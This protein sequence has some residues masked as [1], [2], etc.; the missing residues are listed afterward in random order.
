MGLLA[1][2]VPR[3]ST[4]R[5][6]ARAWLPAATHGRQRGSLRFFLRGQVPNV[7]RYG[8]PQ[9]RGKILS[10]T[11]L[12]GVNTMMG[13]PTV[14]GSSMFGKPV[15]RVEDQR[16]LRGQG[17]YVGDLQLPGTLEGLFVRSPHAHARIVAI[18]SSRARAMPGVEAVFTAAEVVPRTSPICVSGEVHT[19]ERL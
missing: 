3:L 1:V 11:S 16:L 19:P 12:Y 15:R 5:R 13:N 8:G 2:T 14:S 6:F 17:R 10:E 7:P 9:F 4:G 18:D